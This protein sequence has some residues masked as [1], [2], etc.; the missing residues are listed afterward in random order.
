MTGAKKGCYQRWKE[1]KE[2]MRTELDDRIREALAYQTASLPEI[3]GR[4]EALRSR[5]I[6]Q[7]K[8]EQTMKKRD[9]KI[10]KVLA[11]A[12]AMCILGSAAAMAAGN[13]TS[14]ESRSFQEDVFTEYSQI[15]EKA[16]EYQVPFAVKGP[17]TFRNGFSFREGMP[18][19]ESGLDEEGNRTELATAISLTYCKEGMADV[20]LSQSQAA[21]GLEEGLGQGTEYADGDI[22]YYYSQEHYKFVPPSYE[23]SEEEKIVVEAGDLIISYGTDQ[24]EERQ[25]SS[26]S[27][28]SDGVLYILQSFDTELTE[29]EMVEMA[30]EVM[31]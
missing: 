21:A 13:F 19:Y 25:V 23:L 10:K 14:F 28:I 31:E 12:A 4:E 9:W 22:T 18:I 16:E 1:R 2:Q 3:P 30:R 20:T 8:E 5:T 26:V 24:V 7:I 6:R 11:A 15:A 27:W 17:E 29:D